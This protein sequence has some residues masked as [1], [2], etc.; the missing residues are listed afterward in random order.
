M[1]LR[2]VNYG[3]VI[4][5]RSADEKESTLFGFINGGGIVDKESS[6]ASSH[7]TVPPNKTI[8]RAISNL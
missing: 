4:V 5:L 1:T 8:G 3:D 2:Y 6:N 7:P